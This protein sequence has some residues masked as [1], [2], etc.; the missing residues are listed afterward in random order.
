MHFRFAW[1]LCHEEHQCL[2][3][4][5]S[6]SCHGCQVELCMPFRD[7]SHHSDSAMFFP[8]PSRPCLESVQSISYLKLF[9]VYVVTARN[10]TSTG[11]K[12]PVNERNRQVWP[13]VIFWIYHQCFARICYCFLQ[14]QSHF[15]TVL[16]SYKK[17]RP[18]CH[19]TSEFS[20]S[21]HP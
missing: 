4:N 1:F 16:Y 14:G 10:V 19:T 17:D 7:L 15:E 5:H 12:S 20:I 11:N 9:S 21:V 2:I 13:P 8:P 18:K 3:C 6:R